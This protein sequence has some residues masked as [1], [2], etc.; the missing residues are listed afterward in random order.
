MDL[1]TKSTKWYWFKSPFF[2]KSFDIGAQKRSS[3]REP[4]IIDLY[5]ESEGK[6][7]RVIEAVCL[8]LG[9]RDSGS[10]SG[11]CWV[12]LYRD[13]ASL[14][15]LQRNIGTYNGVGPALPD[16]TWSQEQGIVPCDDDGNIAYRCHSTGDMTLD[17]SVIVV[18][19]AASESAPGCE[20]QS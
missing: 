4:E 8:Q 1:Y 16:N 14:Y 20:Q 18:G 13:P 7:P 3:V 6:I 10:S 17:I 11:N 5:A 19:F 15:M 2:L 12:N 9:A